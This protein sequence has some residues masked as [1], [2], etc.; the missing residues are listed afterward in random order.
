MVSFY[1]HI[2]YN[3]YDKE[4][5]NN[6]LLVVVWMNLMLDELNQYNLKMHF[7]VEMMVMLMLLLLVVVVEE[8]KYLI[9]QVHLVFDLEQY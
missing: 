8:D 7:V 6:R 2:E 3:Y 5:H 1:N 9:E 4:I